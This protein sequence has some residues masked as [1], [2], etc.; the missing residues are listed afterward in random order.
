MF[1]FIS[2]FLCETE[3]TKTIQEED[4][5]ILYYLIKCE[6]RSNVSNYVKKMNVKRKKNPSWPFL[7]LFMFDEVKHILVC[8]TREK[9]IQCVETF[10]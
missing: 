2:S 5:F 4:F 7:F 3:W 8:D 10:L 9:K 1:E 6:K